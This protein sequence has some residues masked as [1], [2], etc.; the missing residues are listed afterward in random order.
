MAL[1]IHLAADGP[2]LD[3]NLLVGILI[4]LVIGFLAGP[5][6]RHWLV[7]REWSEASREADLTDDLLRRLGDLP[8]PPREDD[9]DGEPPLRD[10]PVRRVRWPTSR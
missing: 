5:A 1:A 7:Y 2:G 6:L 8:E 9:E 4:G 10:E 3:A